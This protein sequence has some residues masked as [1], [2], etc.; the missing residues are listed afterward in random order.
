MYALEEITNALKVIKEVCSEHNLICEECP[1]R[2]SI[3][4]CA[5]VDSEVVPREWEFYDPQ[6][7]QLIL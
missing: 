6:N 5:I 4:D 7:I 2:K 3:N 1:L